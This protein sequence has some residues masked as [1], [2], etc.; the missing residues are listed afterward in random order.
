MVRIATMLVQ[1]TSARKI[2]MI[3]GGLRKLY[4][5]QRASQR[6]TCAQQDLLIH[7]WDSLEKE[8]LWIVIS[9]KTHVSYWKQLILNVESIKS[10][11]ECIRD[12]KTGNRFAERIIKDWP[13]NKEEIKI[14]NPQYYCICRSLLWRW[15]SIF[16]IQ[17]CCNLLHAL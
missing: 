4:V 11:I 13:R 16:S 17:I 9:I 10:L 15:H 12:D 2:L 1:P 8:H 7:F 5:G 3:I 6:N 14:A